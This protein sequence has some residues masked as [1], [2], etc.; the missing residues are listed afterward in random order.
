MYQAVNTKWFLTVNSQIYM[1]LGSVNLIGDPSSGKM[2]NTDLG[3]PP[4]QELCEI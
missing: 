1:Y 4:P 3:K 2:R